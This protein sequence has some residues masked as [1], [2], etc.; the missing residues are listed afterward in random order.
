MPQDPDSK[1]IICVSNDGS[2]PP[3]E[4]ALKAIKAISQ[5]ETIPPH[6]V[7]HVQG[8]AEIAPT[9]PVGQTT[10]VTEGAIPPKPP[11]RPPSHSKKQSS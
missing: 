5:R 10:L 2:I 8:V 6:V 4:N 3:A 11:I 7:A 1:N 9:A